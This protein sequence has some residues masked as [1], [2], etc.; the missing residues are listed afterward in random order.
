M[1]IPVVDKSKKELSKKEMPKQFEEQ[2][3]DDLIYRA[4]VT[5]Q[6][7]KRQPYG[8]FPDAGMNVSAKLSRRRRDY[9]GSYGH[10]ISRT[11]RK[12]L[13]HRGT[14]FNW[15]GALAP[16]TVGGR[17]AHP[18]KA[19]RIWSKKLNIKER[20]KAICSALS[21]TLDKKTVELRG[22]L[23]PKDFPFI[24]SN[25]VE[26]I[27]K[28]K[29]VIELLYALGFKEDLDR[30]AGKKIR[31]GKGKNRARPYKIKKSI[32]FVV[33]KRCS[34]QKAAA[35]ISGVDIVTPD[36]LNAELLA[37]GA[38]PGRLTL[39]TEGAVDKIAETFKY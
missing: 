21:A 6:S 22:H 2:V 38:K 20:R 23:L 30:T 10:G 28:T 27:S 16:N 34:L 9:K 39:Y 31:A 15:V 37:P 32:L 11:P 4:V 1:K 8:S 5:I 25:D 18:P 7:N 13:S 35:N 24:L 36:H 33:S 3:R 12:I 14:R 17:R 29:D 26:S 19:D